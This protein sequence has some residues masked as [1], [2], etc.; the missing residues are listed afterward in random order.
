MESKVNAKARAK[1][2]LSRVTGSMLANSFHYVSVKVA[3]FSVQLSASTGKGDFP[4]KRFAFPKSRLE[5]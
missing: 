3:V 5:A 1:V 2:V 4:R